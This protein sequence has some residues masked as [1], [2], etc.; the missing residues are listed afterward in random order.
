MPRYDNAQGH[1]HFFDIQRRVVANRTSE[2]WKAPHGSLGVELDV[3]D[4]MALVR[5]L[6]SMPEYEGVRVTFN[7]VLLKIIAEG[8]LKAPE[9]NA[10]IEYNPATA[11]GKLTC[12]DRVNIALP[13]RIGQ[14]HTI[15]PVLED[16]GS[17]SLREL[18]IA[19]E[20]LKRRARNTNVALLLR[21]A[22]VR[23]TRRRALRGDLSVLRRVL[24]NF[25]GKARLPRV[26]REEWRQYRSIPESD[27][28]TPENLVSATT[29]VSNIGSVL[30]NTPLYVHLL[31]VIPPQ[32]TAFGVGPVQRKPV[33]AVNDRG[34]EELVIRSMLSLTICVDHRAMDLEHM[35]DFINRANELC[36]SPEKLLD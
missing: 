36:A 15:T 24:P 4:L 18:C 2:A 30:P 33:V 16:A 31:E 5:R 10:H 9:M 29:L 27:R 8:L 12:A 1:S 21:E 20:D 17:M 14:G 22:G 23:D 13:L 35:L 28:I 11:V 7:S 26:S 25:F 6:R 3:T 34:E 19:M 32:T